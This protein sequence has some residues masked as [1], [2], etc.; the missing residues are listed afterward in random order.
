MGNDNP[1][2]VNKLSRLIGGKVIHIPDRPGEPKKTW[3]NINKIK[4]SL[5]WRPK[6]NFEE[7]VDQILEQIGLWNNAPLWT[8]KSIKRATKSWFRYLK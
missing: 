1:Q 5:K 8:P 3:A 6:I 4:R 7:G 2:S